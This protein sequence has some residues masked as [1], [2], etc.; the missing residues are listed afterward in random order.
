[1]QN[2]LLHLLI[3]SIV[4]FVSVRQTEREL[5]VQ[6]QE[7]RLVQREAHLEDTLFESHMHTQPLVS[8]SVIII[9]NRVNHRFFFKIVNGESPESGERF[10]STR[11]IQ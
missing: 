7:E 5:R 2:T 4:R 10:T 9:N 3:L 1:M 8:Y 6:M 11:R